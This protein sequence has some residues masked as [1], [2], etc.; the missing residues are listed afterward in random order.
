MSKGFFFRVRQD[1]DI[2]TQ[3]VIECTLATG[4]SHGSVV[5]MLNELQSVQRI[6]R[7][8]IDNGTVAIHCT[9]LGRLSKLD[10]LIRDI[11]TGLES[12]GA[13]SKC[14]DCG[15]TERLQYYA[16][17]IISLVLC[18]AC[19][20]NIAKVI[21]EYKQ[22]PNHYAIGFVASLGGALLGSIVWMIVGAYG[23]IASLAAFAIAY[24]AFAAYEKVHGKMTMVGVAINVFTITTAIIF[25][26][27]A[28]LYIDI[29]LEYNDVSI[30]DYIGTT[31]TLF[32]N[33]E[34]I[35]SLLPMLGFGAL[36]G[37][38][39]TFG[40]V[41]K[42]YGTAKGANQLLPVLLSGE[43]TPGARA[44]EVAES[45]TGAPSTRS[46]DGHT[47]VDRHEPLC[48]APSGWYEDPTRR[49]QLRYWTGAEW[50]A[51]VADGGAVSEDPLLAPS[52]PTL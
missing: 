20:I 1:G 31:P 24:L 18:D 48:L 30:L 3:L 12:F 51:A 40:L 45:A 5:R 15:R 38:L 50:H 26:M 13:R 33:A 4:E 10:E 35:E 34:V 19:S 42:Y 43:G 14:D 6:Q 52:T 22:S 32:S 29:A 7:Y 21:E 17:D 25:G 11:S 36:F 8:R 44:M 49:H 28:T 37:V 47:A 16:N 23:L 39:G 27:Y 9:A 41:R 2:E 46:D